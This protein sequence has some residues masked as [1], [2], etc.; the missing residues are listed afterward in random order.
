MTFRITATEPRSISANAA[1][2]TLVAAKVLGQNA[3]NFGGRDVRKLVLNRV[4]GTGPDEEP[5][6]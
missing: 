1:A 5:V 4:G 6:G 2:K 3:R